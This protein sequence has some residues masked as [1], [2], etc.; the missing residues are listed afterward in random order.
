MYDTPYNRNIAAMDEEH[1]KRAILD[2]KARSEGRDLHKNPYHRYMMEMSRLDNQPFN[3]TRGMREDMQQ[4]VML[5]GIKPFMGLYGPTAQDLAFYQIEDMGHT[6]IS[7]PAVETMQGSARRGKRIMIGGAWYNDWDDFVGAV[8]EGVEKVKGIY[9][10]YIKPVLDVVGKPLKDALESMPNPYAQAG[11]EVL[12]LLGY[13][14]Y[15]TLEAIYGKGGPLEGQPMEFSGG[16]WWNNWDDFVDGI[17]SAVSTVKEVLDVVA[18]P[19]K[20]ALSGIDNKY[21]KGAVDVLEMLGYGGLMGCGEYDYNILQDQAALLKE[22]RAEPVQLTKLKKKEYKPRAYNAKLQEMH[23]DLSTGPKKGLS[24]SPLGGITGGAVSAKAQE[25]V[26]GPNN[27]YKDRFKQNTGRS[28]TTLP[29]KP[30]AVHLD[31]GAMPDQPMQ[32]QPH[33]SDDYVDYIK[34]MVDVNDSRKQ[35]GFKPVPMAQ[36]PAQYQTGGA[37][38]TGGVVRTGGADKRKERAAIVKKIMQEKGLKMVEASKY[39]KEHN[40][41]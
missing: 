24:R 40:L 28:G 38:I 6:P 18:T 3:L 31:G 32:D 37:M 10:D 34:Q 30:P 9:S 20:D 41:Y 1:F 4:R 36:L 25:A 11:A 17:K 16:A 27:P 14:N 7:R 8:K 33:W 22:P 35:K 15:K 12:D 39:V 29:P 23:Y 13:G 21:A 19:V 2:Q 5:G 26:L